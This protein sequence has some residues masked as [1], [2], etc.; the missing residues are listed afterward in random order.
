MEYEL[1]LKIFTKPGDN[2]AQ[3]QN[4]HKLNFITGWREIPL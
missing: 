2:F 3:R 4:R 1:Q